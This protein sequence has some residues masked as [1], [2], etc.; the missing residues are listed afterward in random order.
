MKNS[1]S[2][3]KP[4]APTTPLQYARYYLDQGWFIFPIDK[5]GEPYDS[6]SGNCDILR[7]GESPEFEAEKIMIYRD[8]DFVQQYWTA[9]PDANIGIATG[10]VSGIVVVVLDEIFCAIDKWGPPSE[11]IG[12]ISRTP[13]AYCDERLFS[14]FKYP[15]DMNIPNV[16][17]YNSNLF[18]CGDGGY[19]LA[20]PT[21]VEVKY[22]DTSAETDTGDP[23]NKYKSYRDKARWLVMP[24]EYEPMELPQWFRDRI[25]D[26]VFCHYWEEE[27]QLPAPT[28]A[29]RTDSATAFFYPEPYLYY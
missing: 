14:F 21:E 16:N 19:V 18:C 8:Y 22:L 13:T 3:K 28:P 26:V 24:H 5:S 7:A 6:A 2:A 4:V 23:D 12:D 15:H 17:L 20:P 1:I 25:E 11:E 10:M 9:N 27:N 29:R